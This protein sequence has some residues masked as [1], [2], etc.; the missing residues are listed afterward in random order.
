MDQRDVP[1]RWEGLDEGQELRPYQE[2]GW[3]GKT[4]DGEMVRGAIR[5]RVLHEWVPLSRNRVRKGRH[6]Q[7]RDD[8]TVAS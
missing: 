5:T 6:E 1:P 7:H 2:P 8:K 4:K 3:R